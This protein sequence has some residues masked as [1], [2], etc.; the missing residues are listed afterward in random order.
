MFTTKFLH[1]NRSFPSQHWLLDS[2][3]AVA[4]VKSFE[5]PVA[6]VYELDA[7]YKT[8]CVKLKAHVD[9]ITYLTVSS[10]NLDPLFDS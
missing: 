8:S 1:F 6:P 4:P 9:N 7:F 3:L 5:G 10:L 2:S